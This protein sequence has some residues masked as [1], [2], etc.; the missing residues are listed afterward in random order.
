MANSVNVSI[1]GTGNVA[2]N[3]AKGLSKSGYA[4]MLGSRTPAEAKKKMGAL[5]A[6]VTVGT[7]KEAAK[8]GDVIFTAIPFASLPE[9][10]E[11]IGPENLRGKII[12]DNTNVLT[13]SFE[14]A[15]GFSTSGAEELAKLVPGARVVKAFNTVFAEHMG[16][17]TLGKE[18][19]TVFAAGDDEASK[20]VVRTLAE[21]I[22]FETVD[23]GPLKS[24]RYLE[25]MG[26]LN[27]TLGYGLKMG[28]RIGLRLVKE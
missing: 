7:L 21:S 16:V 20:N 4:V 27:I 3:L 18:K 28:S 6:D 24:A 12:V 10:I 2:S 15:I 11:A 1:L 9:T 23:A 25:A 8:F 14:W 22:G 13:P 5:P 19:L 26:I 17:G